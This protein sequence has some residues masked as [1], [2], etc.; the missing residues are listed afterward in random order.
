VITSVRGI[1]G[2]MYCVSLLRRRRLEESDARGP[3]VTGRG[4]PCGPA[5]TQPTP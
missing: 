3:W 1:A 2:L 5:D 4:Q